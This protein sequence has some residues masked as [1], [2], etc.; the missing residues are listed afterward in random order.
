MTELGFSSNER[1]KG[2]S[3][4]GTLQEIQSII[5]TWSQAHG[6]DVET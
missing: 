6:Q 5:G 3:F 4:A 2:I 1:Q